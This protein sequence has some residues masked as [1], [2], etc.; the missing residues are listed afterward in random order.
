MS[1]RML[2]KRQNPSPNW[3]DKLM[4]EIYAR[5][6]L[7][8]P[9]VAF[10]SL[11]EYSIYMNASIHCSRVN[12]SSGHRG[13]MHCSQFWSSDHHY[14]SSHFSITLSIGVILFNCWELVNVIWSRL[15]QWWCWLLHWFQF[16]LQSSRPMR[17]SMKCGKAWFGTFQENSCESC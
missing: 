16:C 8:I 1:Y 3:A 7:F 4:F 11:K 13:V 17:K 15:V 9:L 14:F 2:R 6:G 10:V 5:F 12:L